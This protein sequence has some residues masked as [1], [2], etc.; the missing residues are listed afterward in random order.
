[1]PS[2]DETKTYDSARKYYL[3]KAK[4]LKMNKYETD[5]GVNFQLFEPYIFLIVF[6]NLAM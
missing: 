6:F 1:M 3:E 5:K 2:Q 4:T